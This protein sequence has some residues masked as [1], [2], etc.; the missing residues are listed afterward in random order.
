[1]NGTATA[2]A[3][4][5]T[6]NST[7]GVSSSFAVSS[8][9]KFAAGTL[10]AT[11]TTAGASGH[12]ERLGL[13][14]HPRQRISTGTL[15]ARRARRLFPGHPQRRRAN[16]LQL[17][18]RRAFLHPHRRKRRRARLGHPQERQTARPR[19]R[20]SGGHVWGWGCLQPCPAG[21]RAAGI[22]HAQHGPRAG[23]SRC[24]VAAGLASV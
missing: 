20:I 24:S 19:P 21:A 22:I 15:S 13:F 4:S 5:G 8:S 14:L 16:C 10:S 9:C 3:S 18:A 17:S 12:P 23:V 1:M 2:G 6:A 7:A 11:E